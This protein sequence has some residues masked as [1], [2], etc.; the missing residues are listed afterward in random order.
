MKQIPRR[1]FL[2]RSLVAGAVLQAGRALAD[3]TA[4]A[5]ASAETTAPESTPPPHFDRKLKVGIVGCGGRGSWIARLFAE[6]GGYEFVSAADYFHDRALKAGGSVGVPPDRCFSGLSGFQKVVDSGIEAIILEALSYAFPDHVAAAVKAG[7]HIYMAKPIAVDVPGTLA[8]A[9]HAKAAKR[10]KKVF[11]VDY[12]MTTDLGNIEVAQRVQAGALGELQA[13]W[14]CGNK[15]EK[16][17]EDPPLTENL[18]SRFSKNIWVNDDALG[19]GYLVNYDIHVMHALLWALGKKLPVSAYGR[20]G[21]CRPDPHGDS[22]DTYTITYAFDDGLTWAH[23][24]GI[25]L[26]QDWL[27]QGSLEG[28]IQGHDA[29]ARVSYWKGSYIRGGPQ[30]R[31]RKDIKDLYITGARHNIADFYK[32]VVDQN[33]T[34]DTVDLAVNSCL[35]AVLGREAVKRDGLLTMEQLIRE[36]KPLQPNLGG[37]KP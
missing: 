24:S 3:T 18:E 37:L 20:G 32:R 7:L 8:I 6:H 35:T 25:S 10:A 5:S 26:G 4:T 11:H 34:N 19:G 30:H 1:V 16:G 13:V 27:T 15:D 29:A 9:E 21:R 33:T 23:Q 31:G 14:S 2:E 17:F 28:S 36:N 12:Q 22:N